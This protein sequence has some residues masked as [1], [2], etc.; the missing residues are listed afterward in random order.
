MITQGENDVLLAFADNGHVATCFMSSVLRA[1]SE[2]ASREQRGMKRRLTEYYTGTGPYIHDNRARIARYFLENTN[3]QWLWMVDNDIQFQDDAL[4]YLLEA[5][6]EHDT[7]ILG[8]AYWNRYPGSAC[9]LSWLVFTPRGIVAVPELPSD[10]SKP[11][12]ISAC[13][14][15]CTIIHRE[16]VQDI[17]DMY[18]NDP[19]DTYG[20]DILLTFDDGRSLVGRSMDEL[21]DK[22]EQYESEGANLACPPQR[23]GEDVTFCLRARYAGYPTYGL[24]SL[25]VEHFK[26]TFMPHGLPGE[27]PEGVPSFDLSDRGEVAER[28]KAAL[29]ALKED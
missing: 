2:D 3:K 9:Y 20:A 22:A 14:M 24:P 10:T 18:A 11:V 8:G 29:L 23:M 7:K 27:K 26:P 13:G 6:E 21:K 17:A 15:G 1:F 5:A 12:E 28:D 16:V 4:Y 19:W 25:V